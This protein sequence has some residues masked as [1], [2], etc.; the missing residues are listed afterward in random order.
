MAGVSRRKMEVDSQSLVIEEP[1]RKILRLRHSI[2]DSLDLS[3]LDVNSIHSVQQLSRISLRL[4]KIS[5]LN[6]VVV[7]LIDKLKLAKLSLVKAKV[8]ELLRR[9]VAN[10]KVDCSFIAS[11]I[12]YLLTKTDSHEFRSELLS[13]CCLLTAK[14]KDDPSHYQTM[15]NVAKQCLTDLTSSVRASSLLLLGDIIKYGRKAGLP[16]EDTLGMQL[17]VIGFIKDPEPRVRSIALET[18]LDLHSCGT[19]LES[20]VY[21]QASYA[22]NDDYERVRIAAL[23]LICTLAVD[24]PTR[25][26]PLT[27][28]KGGLSQSIVMLDDG[29]AKVCDAINDVS[30]IVRT[31]AAKLMAKFVGVSLHFLEQTLYKQL[32]SNMKRK[33]SGHDRQRELFESGDWASGKRFADD[34]PKETL[35]EDSESLI[36]MGACGAFVHALEDEYMEVRGAAVESMCVLAQSNASYARQTQDFLVD[37]FNDEIQEV[38]LQAIRALCKLSHHLSLRD[39]QVEIIT[40]VLKDYGA[41][42]RVGIHR[43]IQGCAV[44]A[45]TGL[46]DVI[47]ALLDNMRR[48]P[49]DKQ[50]IWRVMKGIGLRHSGLMSPLIPELLSVDPHFDMPEPNMD[51][52]CYVA[53]M[54]A[55]YNSA[56]KESSLASLF[57]SYTRQHYRFHRSRFPHLIPVVVQLEQEDM[58]RDLSIASGESSRSGRLVEE[59]E[60]KLQRLNNFTQSNSAARQQLLALCL[61]DLKHIKKREGSENLYRA[62]YLCEYIQCLL[63]FHKIQDYHREGADKLVLSLSKQI[64]E[65]CERLLNLYSGT[66]AVSNDLVRQFQLIALTID[67]SRKMETHQ[68]KPEEFKLYLQQLSKIKRRLTSGGGQL[69]SVSRLLDSQETLEAGN[70]SIL[71]SVLSNLDLADIPLPKRINQDISMIQCELTEPV[72]R[73]DSPRKFTANLAVCLPV[74][75]TIR[76]LGDNSQLYIMVKLPDQTEVI[77]PVKPS[78]VTQESADEHSL[79]TQVVFSHGQWSENSYAEVFVVMQGESLSDTVEICQ[80]TRVYLSTRPERKAHIGSIM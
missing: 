13:L 37:M 68:A 34:A 44:S 70:W 27:S 28:K 26:L 65:L 24:T 3:T 54:I 18:L 58:V 4:N 25:L 72:S 78:Q 75:A 74:R 64:V 41:D 9:I 80:P 42:I 59:V 39:D 15:M 47:L 30:F 45:Q 5:D 62:S 76:N 61:R 79:T 56:S 17:I 71:H 7:G 22:A 48:Y 50:S 32:M 60:E 51:D 73:S 21:D 38:R 52:D 1:P 35:D 40:G 36:T 63:L 6:E 10:Y 77:C 57:P 67:I 33:Q 23:N 55:V 8:V 31:Q 19:S 11:E 43:L 69:L 14:L 49:V 2:D 66:S 20:T 16:F 12:S 53:V 46:R 29:F